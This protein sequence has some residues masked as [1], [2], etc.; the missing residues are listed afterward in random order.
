[1]VLGSY[2]V[3][4]AQILVEGGRP[5]TNLDR[6]VGCMRLAAVRGCRLVVLP[7]CLDLGWTDPSARDL[8]RP[9]PGPQILKTLNDRFGT[10]FTD[11][12]KVFIQQLEEKLGR[13]VIQGFDGS[14]DY[15][16]AKKGVVLTTS[17]FKGRTGL[18]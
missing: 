14:M 17:Q 13:P 2:K 9:I 6:A 11:D 4:M 10:D 5:E 12:D 7:E 15:I 8:A 1:M 3:G 18:R 16:R